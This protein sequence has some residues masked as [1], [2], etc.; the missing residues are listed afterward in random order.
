VKEM[1]PMV[2]LHATASKKITGEKSGKEKHS[3]GFFF[4]VK[5]EKYFGHVCACVFVEKLFWPGH[6][7]SPPTECTYSRKATG[8][9]IIII[10]YV[11]S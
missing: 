5:N 7:K 1:A 4:F 6:S 11:R 10:I 9:I 2:N 3:Q 8:H